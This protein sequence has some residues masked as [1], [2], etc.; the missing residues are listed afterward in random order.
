[1][2]GKFLCQSTQRTVVL[3]YN[4]IPVISLLHTLGVYQSVTEGAAQCCDSDLQRVGLLH[5]Q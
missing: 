5:Q 3:Q 1:M 2:N 4:D